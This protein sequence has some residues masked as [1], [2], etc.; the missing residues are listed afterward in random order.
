MDDNRI[1]NIEEDDIKNLPPL[2]NRQPYEYIIMEGY[3]NI[4]DENENKL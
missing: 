2:E 3:K 1:I 4:K